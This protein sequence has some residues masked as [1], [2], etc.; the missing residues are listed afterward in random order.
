LTGNKYHVAP[1]AART[2]DGIVFD[3]KAEM[4]RY[5]ELR[6]LQWSGHITGLVCQPEYVLL[7]PFAATGRRYRGIKYRPDFQ[8][9]E[10][11]KIV[12]EDVKGV[13]T[14]VYQLKRQLMAKLYPD[15]IFREI[16]V[17]R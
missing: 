12:V 3:S 17:G 9:V 6:L 14:Q 10:G 15:V 5:L 13:R 2:I 8:Y 11:G 4:Q 16:K 1:D 7:A